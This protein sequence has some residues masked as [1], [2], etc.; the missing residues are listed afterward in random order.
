MANNWTRGE[1]IIALNIY[2]KVPYSKIT[3]SNTLIQ[4]TA[5]VIERSVGGVVFKL[6]NFASL[7]PEVK[8][9]GKKGF[10][11]RNKLDESIWNEFYS[12]WEELSWQAHQLIAEYKNLTIEESLKIPDSNLPSEG[13]ERLSFVKQRVNQSDFREKI[14][15]NYNSTCCITGIQIPELLIASHIKPWSIDRDNRMNPEN[16]ICLNALH[17]KAFDRGFFTIKPNYELQLSEAIEEITDSLN[18]GFLKSSSSIN[19]PERFKPDKEF[20]KWHNENVFLGSTLNFQ[21]KDY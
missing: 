1:L 8:K 3:K 14:L 12:N 21:L 6:A 18:I 13:T 17:D 19:L 11:H 7:D 16:G 10:D 15:S 2:F 5:N 9:L 4:E 20:L